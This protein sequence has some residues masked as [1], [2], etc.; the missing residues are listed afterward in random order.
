MSGQLSNSTFNP[1]LPDRLCRAG[2][3]RAGT[4]AHSLAASAPMMPAFYSTPQNP[5]M[6]PG[7]EAVCFYP[8]EGSHARAMAL[9]SSIFAI[10]ASRMCC[11]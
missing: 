4:C 10:F 7:C 5:I 1:P 11:I 8:P 6:R 3:C 2:I 9:E